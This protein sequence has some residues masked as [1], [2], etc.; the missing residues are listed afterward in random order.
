MKLDHHIVHVMKQIT[1]DI[2]DAAKM[3]VTCIKEGKYIVDM[4]DLVEVI[5]H[6][7]YNV[8]P[9][10]GGPHYPCQQSLIEMGIVYMGCHIKCAAIHL[11]CMEQVS[12]WP[13][14]WFL[15]LSMDLVWK[16]LNNLLLLLACRQS[17]PPPLPTCYHAYMRWNDD[18]KAFQN[19]LQQIP[20]DT[21][22][23]LDSI[24]AFIPS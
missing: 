6:L 9:Y 18:G 12:D 14:Q 3:R 22:C 5:C 21:F 15:N 20:M 4:I 24:N 11:L 23:L 19:E 10:S 1:G 7:P 2:Q 16:E 8:E 13:E 17:P